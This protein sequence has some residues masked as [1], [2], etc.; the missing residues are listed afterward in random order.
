MIWN[1][2]RGGEAE[3][4]AVEEVAFEHKFDFGVGM[5]VDLLD[6]EDFEHHDGVIGLTAYPSGVESSKD[7]LK[8]V[9]IDEMNNFREDIVREILIENIIAEGQLTIVLFEHN[10][11]PL[12]FGLF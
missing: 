9:P 7:F 10:Q 6:D 4:S 11:S 3:E 8:R 5:A 2:I 12:V 1:R